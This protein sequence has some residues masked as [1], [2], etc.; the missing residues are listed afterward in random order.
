MG[1]TRYRWR[2]RGSHRILQA[3]DGGEVIVDRVGVVLLCPRQTRL[4]FG[5]LSGR[6][7]TLARSGHYQPISLSRL[8]HGRSRAIDALARENQL[9]VGLIDLKSDGVRDRIRLSHGLANA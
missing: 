7:V 3:F 1:S 4:R 2:R 6:R 5:Q 9:A 8:I